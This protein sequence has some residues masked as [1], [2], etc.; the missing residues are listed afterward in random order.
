MHFVFWFISA[1]KEKMSTIDWDHPGQALLSLARTVEQ[2]MGGTSGAVSYTISL[3]G[4]AQRALIK[5]KIMKSLEREWCKP[6]LDG[7]P[8][9]DS[10]PFNVLYV[11]VAL[12]S[13][14]DCWCQ[15]CRS[16]FVV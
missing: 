6:W 10:K 14:P 16:C 9:S 8:H 4:Y 15:C 11:L 3:D 13:V 7:L 2:H 12:C 1:I 5:I